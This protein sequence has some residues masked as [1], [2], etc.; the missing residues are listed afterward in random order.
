MSWQNLAKYDQH[1]AGVAWEEVELT[2][3]AGSCAAAGLQ[4]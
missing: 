1:P 2:V 4:S 3:D